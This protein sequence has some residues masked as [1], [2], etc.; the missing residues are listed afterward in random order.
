MVKY[1]IKPIT[2]E[3]NFAVFDLQQFFCFHLF[4]G[5]DNGLDAQSRDRCQLL[6]CQRDFVGIEALVITQTLEIFQDAADSHL[7]IF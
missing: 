2:L 7:R 4:N 3:I 5:P 1:S 6:S